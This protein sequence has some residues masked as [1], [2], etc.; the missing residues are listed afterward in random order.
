[1]KKRIIVLALLSPV[2]LLVGAIALLPSPESTSTAKSA[3]PEKTVN[4]LKSAK[5]ETQKPVGPWLLTLN[6]VTTQGPK[7]Q[8]WI[9]DSKTH[10]ATGQWA[11]AHIQ[12]RNTSKARQSLKEIFNWTGATI[13]DEKGNKKEP[14]SD[15]TDITKLREFEEKPFTPGE[16]RTIKL[17]FDIP[18]DASIQRLDLA[19]FKS[20]AGIK[21]LPAQ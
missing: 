11:T 6:K 17:S 16:V 12:V 5:P 9:D 14:D 20:Q 15:V 19:S 13:L 8:D 10:E 4:L 1:M 3:A 2:V 21:V 7:M 18:E